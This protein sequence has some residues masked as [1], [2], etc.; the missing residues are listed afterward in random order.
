VLQQFAERKPVL[1]GGSRLA[2][3]APSDAS[4][5]ASSFGRAGLNVGSHF[6]PGRVGAWL[7]TRLSTAGR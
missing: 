6:A 7:T 1:V 4:R 2:K 5:T 3:L